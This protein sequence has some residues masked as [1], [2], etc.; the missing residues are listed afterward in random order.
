MS[1]RGFIYALMIKQFAFIFLL[2]VGTGCTQF[3]NHQPHANERDWPFFRGDASL[4]GYTHRELPEQPQLLWSYQSNE[5]TVSSPVVYNE[6]VYWCDR[7]GKVLGINPEGMLSFEY[8]FK[9]AVE[10]TPMI[11]DST[12]FI[13]RIDGKM[14]ALSL[15]T[16]DTLWSYETMGQISASPNIIEFEKKQ[17]IIFGS[18]DNYMY[19]VDSQTGKEIK[20]FA[21]GYYI[22]GAVA[23]SHENVVFGGCDAWIRIINTTTGVASDSM[24]ADAYIPSS[25]AFSGNTCYV[26]D[27]MGNIYELVLENNKIVHSRKILASDDKNRTFVSVPAVSDATLYLL[28]D[29]RNLYAIHRKDGSVKWKYLQ[30]GLSGESSPLVCHDKVISC[31]KTGIVS[32][33]DTETGQLLWEYDTGEQIVASPAVIQGCFYILTAK[34]TL[35]CFGDTKK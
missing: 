13:G 30:K 7:R 12:L 15:T 11:H 29:D 31:T 34:G 33:L 35:F 17:T 32:V 2:T 18:Y 14:I 4:S 27:Y 6:V 5:R 28:S 10:S 25:P 16:K 20:R 9:T 19:C 3:S 21:S 8:D 22:N 23:V 26:A 24:Q 1:D